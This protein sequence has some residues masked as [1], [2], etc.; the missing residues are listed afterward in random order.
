MRVVVD[1]NVLVSAL[2]TERGTARRLVD[3]L[4]AGRFEPILTPA[5]AIELLS[6]V[7]RPKFRTRVVNQY[8][9]T[10]IVSVVDEF[11]VATDA[12]VPSRDSGDRIVI[13]AAV[14]GEADMIVTGDRDLLDDL[15]LRAWLMARGIE[16]TTPAEF[17]RQL[18]S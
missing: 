1:T 14:A 8:R 10:A 9:L 12:I 16:V 17:L 6:V 4:V 15:D 11:A 2:I 7:W 5:M 18:D 3:A 13:E